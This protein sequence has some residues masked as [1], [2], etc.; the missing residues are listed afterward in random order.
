MKAREGRHRAGFREEVG[1]SYRLCRRG[2]G[3][4]SAAGDREG[5]DCVAQSAKIREEADSG[6]PTRLIASVH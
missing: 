4:P 2:G 1:S 6:L 3:P 5:P